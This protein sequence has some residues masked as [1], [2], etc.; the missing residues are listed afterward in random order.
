MKFITFLSAWKSKERRDKETG[1][2]IKIQ[3]KARVAQLVTYK[4]KYLDEKN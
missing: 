4:E 2:T 1:L 3:S